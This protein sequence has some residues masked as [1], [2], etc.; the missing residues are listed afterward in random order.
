MA[1]V[2]PRPQSA[3]FVKDVCIYT[4]SNLVVIIPRIAIFIHATREGE[5]MLDYIYIYVHSSVRSA[6]SLHSPILRHMDVHTYVRNFT[7]ISP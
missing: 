3:T 2:T 6:L 7:F 5:K 1:Y 4:Q